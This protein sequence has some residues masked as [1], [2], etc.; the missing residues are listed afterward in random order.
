MRSALSHSLFPSQPKAKPKAKAIASDIPLLPLWP[1]VRA[2]CR[3]FAGLFAALCSTRSSNNPDSQPDRDFPVFAVCS[4]APAEVRMMCGVPR[5]GVKGQRRAAETSPPETGRPIMTLPLL[6]LSSNLKARLPQLH[7]RL[8]L[9]ATICY[10]P[11]LYHVQSHSNTLEKGTS[12]IRS[13][14]QNQN[15][16][17]STSTST[18]ISVP[19]PRPLSLAIDP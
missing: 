14:T 18:S 11:I 17:T 5:F 15:R 4:V 13:S 9:G 6:L 1:I 19:F 16:L 12:S 8:P 2:T 3:A 7:W 10:V